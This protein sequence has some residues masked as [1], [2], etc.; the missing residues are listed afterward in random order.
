[1][2]YITLIIILVMIA[3]LMFTIYKYLFYPRKNTHIQ[4]YYRQ[5]NDNQSTINRLFVSNHPDRKTLIESCLKLKDLYYNG[6][7]DK[8]DNNGN[9][10]KGVQPNPSLAVFYINCAIQNGY[11]KGLIDL[12]KMYHYGFFDFPSNLDQAIQIYQYAYNQI[13]DPLLLSEIIDLWRSATHEN[14]EIKTHRWLNIPYNSTIHPVKTLYE[15]GMNKQHIKK[16]YISSTYNNDN[17][18]LVVNINN[19]FRTNTNG[20]DIHEQRIQNDMH[21]VHDHAVITSIQNSIDKLQKDTSIDIDCNTSMY[22]LRQYINTLSESDKKNDMLKTL[23]TIENSK[24]PLAFSSLSEKEILNLVWNRINSKEHQID[25]K[26]LKENLVDELAEC[27]EHGKPVC[28]TGRFTRILDSLNGVDNEVNIK[29]SFMIN[30]EMMTKSNHIRDEEYNKLPE[31]QKKLVD[32]VEPN[33]FQK[34]WVSK[35]KDNITNQ[36]HAD[37]V[38]TN[39]IL[40]PQFKEEINKWI[41]DI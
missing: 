35:L 37:Y 11:K 10:I 16:T 39:L 13:D 3:I 22:Q 38:D 28:S 27:I 18:D 31:D 12:A 24:M 14:D 9:K 7:P 1:M 40:E 30:D 34:S 21:N 17:D 8:Y 23:S 20:E 32:S 5:L 4:Q 36:L 6:I 41:D 2:S 25:A 33:E 29:S 26:V 15:L 19:L